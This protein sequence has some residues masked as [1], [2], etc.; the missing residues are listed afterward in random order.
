MI[1]SFNF[2]AT[3]IL[4]IFHII[5]YQNS[6]ITKKYISLFIKLE[7]CKFFIHWYALIIYNKKR[8]LSLFPPNILDQ[9]VC[10]WLH[11][12]MFIWTF[13]VGVFVFV[14]KILD[15]TKYIYIDKKWHFK[16]FLIF[17]IFFFFNIS[18]LIVLR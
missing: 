8:Y 17:I 14:Y 15:I 7:W 13:C 1:K 11:A 4:I 5:V 3:Q 16:L 6:V 12:Y 18:T 9:H 2:F 10:L